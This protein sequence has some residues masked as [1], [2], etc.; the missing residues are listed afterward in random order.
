MIRGD[1]WPRHVQGIVPS[2]AKALA[3]IGLLCMT[4]S[5]ESTWNSRWTREAAMDDRLMKTLSLM[6]RSGGVA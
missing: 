3:R 1:R 6:R 5:P 4:R 2:T